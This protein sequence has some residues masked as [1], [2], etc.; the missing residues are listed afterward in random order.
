MDQPARTWNEV[1]ADEQERLAQA[2]A[3]AQAGHSTPQ[4]RIRIDLR[5][6]TDDGLVPVRA[7]LAGRPVLVREHVTV[8]EPDGAVEAQA[9]VE[10]IDGDWLHLR[11]DW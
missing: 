7:S 1:L 5:A 10:R 8:Y 3:R 6:R 4:V 2:V 11:V 9:V